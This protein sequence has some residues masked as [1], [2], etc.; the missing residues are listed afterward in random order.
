MIDRLETLRAIDSETAIAAGFAEHT[1]RL[2][3]KLGVP[4]EA[5]NMA[6]E[7]ARATIQALLGGDVCTDLQT[8]A[9]ALGMPEGTVR[10]S[11]LNSGV[12]K[13]DGEGRKLPLVLDNEGRIYLYRY[14][15]YELQLADALLRRIP[16]A[17]PPSLNADVR[18]FLDR[19]FAG[20]AVRLSGRPDWQKIAVVMGLTNP[21]TIISGGP[22]TGKTTIVTTLCAALAM[23]DS[24]PRIALAAPTGKA[25]ARME[26]AI[27]G[28]VDAIDPAIRERLPSRSSTIHMLLGA[29]P[30]SNEYQYNRDNP[31]PYDLVVVDEASMVDLALA[32]RLFTAMPQGGHIVLLGDKDQLASVQAGAIFA[33]LARHTSFTAAMADHLSNETGIS[34]TLLQTMDPDHTGLADCVVWL[35]ENY[36]FGPES[37]I[38]QLAALVRDSNVAELVGWL[39]NQGNGIVLWRAIGVGLP[40]QVIGELVKG[41]E[42]YVKAVRLGDPEEALSAFDNFCVLCAIHRGCRGVQG[43]NDILTERL[44]PTLA[45]EKA[46]RSVWFHGRSVMVTENDYGLGIFNGDIGI[47]LDDSDGDLKVWFT[48]RDG[49]VR[50]IAPPRLPA[51]Q[52]AFAITVHKS[53]GSEFENVALILP[54]NDSP[55][56][57]RELI[58]TAV[59]R[60]KH[61]LALYGALDV[62]RSAVGR[63]TIRRSG[64]AK[65]IANY[66]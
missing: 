7:A 30:E 62:L 37:P 20:N 56:L 2:A 65:R 50:A 49:G 58:Y 10:V 5:A 57:T 12:V 46:G 19:R 32:A 26:E 36:R 23:S 25:A 9:A 64:L 39:H 60:A 16:T 21:L 53:Q 3:T 41:F 40:E 14:F 43:I 59:T 11:L 47:A 35:K 15:D 1:K 55:V 17:K 29:R 52:T 31:L 18:A 48:S 61:G 33:E 28:Q 8:I 44:R 34:Q 4:R 38:G 42:P 51:H 6:G 13:A 45:G 22:G 27:R 54:E 24:P 63:P 66:G